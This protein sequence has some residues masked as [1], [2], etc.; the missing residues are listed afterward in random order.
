MHLEGPY[1]NPK[2]F[3][4]QDSKYIRPPSVDEFREILKAANYAVRLVTLA[5]EVEGAKKRIVELDLIVED[6]L[7]D[8]LEWSQKVEY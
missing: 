6:N 3:G 2:K 4:G 7:E 8:A 1:I 5:P